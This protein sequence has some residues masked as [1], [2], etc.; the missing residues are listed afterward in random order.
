L[1]RNGCFALAFYG[2]K[3]RYAGLG[4]NE[5][6]ELR[7][8]REENRKLKT[9]VADLSLDKHILQEVLSKKACSPRELVRR[10]RQAHQLNESRACGLV[11]I[12]QWINRYQ[13]RRDPQDQLRQHLRELAGNR[14]RY[15]YRRLS[16]NQRWSMDLV[17]DRLA[18]GR[19]IGILTVVDQYTRECLRAYADRSQTESITT[20]NDDEF[21][22]K[23]METWAYKNGA[24]LDLIRPGKPVENGYI[25]S[26]N[27]QLR[28]ECLNIE[29][30][31]T[32]PMRG[33]TR[34]LAP[35]LQ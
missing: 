5:L 7:Q 13:S 25:E 34:T 3:R 2:W 30:S 35:R 28:D 21:A 32:W 11:G 4:L 22:G 23:A 26:L 24:K 29:S 27:G 8:L 17:R 20:N 6:R 15:G 16:P 1:P 10:I 31:S 14:P 18:D 12:I 33:K 9:M 19:W